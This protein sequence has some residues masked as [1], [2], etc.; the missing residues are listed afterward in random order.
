MTRRL[1]IALLAAASLAG[2]DD[3]EPTA[4]TEPKPTSPFTS[5][6]TTRLPAGGAVSRTFTT[7][8]N[9]SITVHLKSTTPSTSIGIGVGIPSTGLGIGNCTLSLSAQTAGDAVAQLSAASTPDTYCV[10]AWDPGTLTNAIDI[11]ATIVYP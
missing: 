3:T 1:L 4:P 11:D 10:V 8:Q 7:T 9:G 5:T 2:C 6:L